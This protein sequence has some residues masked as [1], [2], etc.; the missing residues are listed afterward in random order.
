MCE[1]EAEELMGCEEENDLETSFTAADSIPTR[2]D[3]NSNRKLFL[4]FFNEN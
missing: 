4:H 2:L 3:L 1:T